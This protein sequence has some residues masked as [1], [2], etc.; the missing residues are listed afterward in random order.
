MGNCY[1]LGDATVTE[2]EVARHIVAAVKTIFATMIF[3]EDIVEDYPLEKPVSHFLCSISGMVGLG[4]AF[5]G[6]VG[7][8]LPE[9]FALEATASMLGMTSD[10][11]DAETDINDAVGEI[12]NM[13]AGEVKMLFSDKNLTLC[14]STPSII[15]GKDYTIEVMSNNCAVIVPFFRGEQRF[16]ATLQISAN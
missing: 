11:V 13:L 8:H 7:L 12:T 14:L 10:E 1:V 4:G 6:M 2:E 15:S 3:I 5:S 16:I 9:D